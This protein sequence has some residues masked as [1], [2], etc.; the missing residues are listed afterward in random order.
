MRIHRPPGQEDKE[1]DRN[2]NV[3]EAE[4]EKKK[5]EIVQGGTKNKRGQGY[6]RVS[7]SQHARKNEKVPR[8]RSERWSQKRSS[9]TNTR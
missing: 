5:R 7:Q 4:G 2:E 9:K 1:I 3:S 8:L 6:I